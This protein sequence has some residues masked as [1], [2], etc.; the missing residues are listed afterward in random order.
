MRRVTIWEN[1]RAWPPAAQQPLHLIL[2][3]HRVVTKHTTLLL[4]LSDHH[5]EATMRRTGEAREKKT[6]AVEHAAESRHERAQGGAHV[7]WRRLSSSARSGHRQRASRDARA[8]MRCSRASTGGSTQ[9]LNACVTSPYGCVGG[10][11]ATVVWS[12]LNVG[13]LSVALCGHR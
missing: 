7:R 8:R 6:A 5:G 2:S 10:S 3:P 4:F 1:R 11:L 12:P 13:P 9:R